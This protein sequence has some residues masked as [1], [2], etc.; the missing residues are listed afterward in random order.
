MGEIGRVWRGGFG[1]KR[2]K[3][4][5]AEGKGVNWTPCPARLTIS[6][7]EGA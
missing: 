3:N 4:R 7:K 1:E 5:V 2:G 6:R